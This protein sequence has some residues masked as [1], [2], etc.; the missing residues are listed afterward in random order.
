MPT[1]ESPEK[2]LEVAVGR[3]L[4]HSNGIDLEAVARTSNSRLGTAQL[5]ALMLIY[6]YA[7]VTGAADLLDI[8]D[9]RRVPR[10]VLE[11]TF[12]RLVTTGFATRSGAEYSLTPAGSAEVGSAR[13]VI[14]SWITETLTQ[15][16]EFQG[17]PERIHV[18]SALDRIAR[19]VLVERESARRQSRPPKLGPPQRYIAEQPTTRMRAPRPDEPPTRPF[20][21]HATTP[22]S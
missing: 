3:L 7:A 12:D 8:A 11:P 16:D 19:G 1:T 2:L 18:Q 5:W 10:Q 14:S 17:A 22:H 15:S 4:Q 20:R 21:A 13:N 9:D 6:R